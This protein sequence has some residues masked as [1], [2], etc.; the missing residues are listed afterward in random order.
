MEI[1]S[2][3]Y[4]KTYKSTETIVYSCQYH[5]IWA[6]K[7]RRKLLI[8]DIEQDLKSLIL[9]KQEIWNYN[10]IEMEIMPDHIHLLI[11]INPQIG[12]NSTI[13]KIKGYTSNILR[14]KYKELRTKV[15]TL[16]TRSYYVETVGHISEQTVQKYIENQKNK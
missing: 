4:T 5:V 14:K 10:I 15:P 2:K 8:S 16:W 6:T 12:I 1:Q 13:G 11:D 9:E 3:N 7:Y